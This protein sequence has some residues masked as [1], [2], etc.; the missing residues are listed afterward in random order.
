MEE[1]GL[2]A[3]ALSTMT[4][5]MLTLELGKLIVRRLILKN[6]T[7]DFP[8]WVYLVFPPVLNALWVVPLAYLGFQGFAIPADWAD[9]G[10]NVLFVLITSLGTLAEYSLTLKPMKAY[11]TQRKIDADALDNPQ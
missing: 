6:P 4:L 11:G 1:F 8:S 10:R 5:A 7:Y 3:T 9:W 2:G